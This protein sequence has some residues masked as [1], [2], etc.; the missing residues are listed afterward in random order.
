VPLITALDSSEGGRNHLFRIRGLH[1]RSLILKVCA[2]PADNVNR[3]RWAYAQFPSHLVPRML[4]TAR[5][6]DLREQATAAGDWEALRHL[7]HPVGGLLWMEALPGK[8]ATHGLDDNVILNVGEALGLI[9]ALHPRRGPRLLI[10]SDPRGILALAQDGVV[11]ASQWRALDTATLRTLRR[12]VAH[13]GV[14]LDRA[15]HRCDV[16]RVRTLCHGDLRWGNIQLHRHHVHFVDLEHAGLGDPAVDLAFMACRTPLDAHEEM[17]L[18]DGYL[19]ARR[20][21]T[22]LDRYF[23]VKPALALM[24]AV[25]AVLDLARIRRGER[26]VTRDG[27]THVRNREKCILSELEMALMLALRA[28]PS[29]RLRL[30]KTRKARGKR[31]WRGVVAVDGTAASGKSVVAQGLADRLRI[32]YFNTGAAYRAVALHAL[33]QGL[34]PDRDADVAALLCWLRGAR[35]RLR[36]G[37]GVELE[38][39]LR[40]RA[41]DVSLVESEVASWA[42][43]GP[44]RRVLNAR[45]LPA[46]GSSAAVVEGRDV[47]TVLFPQAR[48]KLYVDAALNVRATR[49]RE[50][51][52]HLLT[53][54][55]AL[56]LVRAR[57]QAD[58]TRALAPLRPAA[59]AC[60]LDTTHLTMDTALIRALSL[61]GVQE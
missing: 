24:G 51:C 27:E 3:E 52:G 28:R 34:R 20:D 57:D 6:A 1:G 13:V 45:F 16:V 56:R 49:L 19:R 48:H 18:L 54:S 33:E 25:E 8:P 31:R 50:R 35:L 46:L 42:A 2:S 7:D 58:M 12:A 53:H 15:W 11:Q 22:L 47:G 32:P 61:L 26:A 37:G 55:A 44:V 17:C 9:H 43:L 21:R 60:C 5:P 14:H 39:R 4:G 10:G 30:L 36:D 23:T 38:G 29:H 41:L 40:H 59:D